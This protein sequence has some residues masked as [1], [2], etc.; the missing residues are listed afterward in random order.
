MK[1]FFLGMA[2]F[3]LMTVAGVNTSANAAEV[4]ETVQPAPAA[5]IQGTWVT[6]I[7]NQ[8]DEELRPN[9]TKA[10]MLITFSGQHSSTIVVDFGA[11]MEQDGISVDFA[12]KLTLNGSYTREGDKLTINFASATPKTE[13][14]KLK[15]GGG[16]EVQALVKSLGLEKTLNESLAKEMASEEM[17][18]TFRGMVGESTITRLTSSELVLTDDD[19]TVITFKKKVATKK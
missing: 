7:T 5:S 11:A 4:A 1:K 16:A 9:L 2:A 6:D 12:A 14:Y 17:L 19:E 8:M 13:I 18:Q 15:F 10:E 3:C